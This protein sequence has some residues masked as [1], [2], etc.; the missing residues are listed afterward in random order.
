MVGG[1]RSVGAQ[2]A[3]KMRRC[4]LDKVASICLS[5]VWWVFI[6]IAHWLPK[7]ELQVNPLFS[8]ASV[9]INS[10]RPVRY[11]VCDISI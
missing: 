6:L 8:S 9:K 11:K 4:G 7:N 5:P 1:S 2:H 3:A 10:D